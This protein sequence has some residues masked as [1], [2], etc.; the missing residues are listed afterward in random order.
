LDAGGAGSEIEGVWASHRKGNPGYPASHGES[1]GT[2]GE[3]Q[4]EKNKGIFALTKKERRKGI[5]DCHPQRND[6]E[7]QEQKS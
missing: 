1:H 6:I 4:A 3:A 7:I 2:S 5:Y